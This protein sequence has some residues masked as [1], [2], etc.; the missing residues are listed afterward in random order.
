[1]FN[2]IRKFVFVIALMAISIAIV[3][4]KNNRFKGPFHSIKDAI[5]TE[6]AERKDADIIL[7]SNIDNILL[8]PGPKG[9]TGEQGLAGPKGDKGDTGE[10]GLAGPKGD[11]GDAGEPGLDIQSRDLLCTLYYERGK[12]MPDFCEMHNRYV[13]ITSILYNGDLGGADGADMKCQELAESVGFKSRFKAW[14]SDDQGNGPVDR[15]VTPNPGWFNRYVNMGGQIV[16]ETW[17]GL[18]DGA[19]DNKIMYDET[20]NQV[21]DWWVWTAVKGD[22]TAYELNLS[23]NPDHTD[24]CN[25]WTTSSNDFPGRI[26]SAISYSSSDWTLYEGAVRRCDAMLHLYCFEQ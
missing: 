24:N 8:A 7:Q 15:F 2:H 22:G 26:G 20:G 1:M 4:A 14:I 13:F 17:W 9:D 6:T 10:Q 18:L 5:E 3:N 12:E 19:L 16:S 25:G 21:V 23:Y 11:K